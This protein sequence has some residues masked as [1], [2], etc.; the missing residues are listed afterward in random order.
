MSWVAVGVAAVGATKGIMDANANK[1][2]QKKLDAHRKNVIRYSPWTGMQDPGMVSAG[3]Q[4]AF[5]GAL[6]GGMQGFMLGSG[7]SNAAGLGQAAAPAGM[8]MGAAQTTTMVDPGMM[9]QQMNPMG[10]M[11]MDP[12]QNPYAQMGKMY[13]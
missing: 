7:I 12:M 5:G 6:S 1:K 9:Q 4:D 11:G 8:N 2:R 10:G 13:A 3:N